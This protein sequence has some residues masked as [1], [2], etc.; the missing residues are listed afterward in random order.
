MVYNQYKVNVFVVLTFGGFFLRSG[1]QK[2]KK[3]RKLLFCIYICSVTVAV[4]L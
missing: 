3:M 4:M 1:K 2:K